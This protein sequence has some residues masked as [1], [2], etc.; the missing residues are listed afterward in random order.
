[1]EASVIGKVLRGKQ[2]A[3]L[4]RYLYGP[5]K[6]NEHVN[7]HLVAGFEH[8]ASLEPPVRPDGRR[9]FRRLTGLLSDPV[10]AL[11][12][13]NYDKPVWHC[14]VRA[15]PED[16]V[17]SDDEWADIAHT[18]MDRTG[19]SPYGDDDGVRWV[20]VRHAADHIHIVATLARQDATRPSVW[21]DFYKVRD[22]C[23]EVER[24]YGLRST[25]PGDR[26]AARRPTRAETEQTQRRGWREAPRTALRRHVIT[27]AASSG[28]EIE[29]FA[30]L[31]H[32]GVLVRK[33]MSEVTP[34]EVTGYAVALEHHTTPTGQVV[35]YG[36]GKL[37]ADLTLPKLRRRWIRPDRAAGEYQG[38]GQPRTLGSSANYRAVLRVAA[39]KAA[40][41]ASNDWEFFA[42]L[43]AAGVL[44]RPRLS[45]H[46]PGQVTGYALGIPDNLDRDG[47]QIWYG[48]AKLAADL[49]LPQLRQR[50]NNH[51]PDA[52]PGVPEPTGEE[53]TAIWDHAATTAST[54][55]DHIRAC[56]SGRTDV[57][58]D[59][60][61]ATSD[62]L[63][64]AAEALGNPRLQRVADGFDRAARRPYGRIPPA[65][66]T[67]RRLRG[68]VRLMALAGN[69]DYRTRLS[70]RLIT[71][72][73]ALADVVADLR[74][75]Q[76]RAAQAAA[77]RSAAEQ[78]VAVVPGPRSTTTLPSARRPTR[79]G[80][81]D[82]ARGDFPAAPR[83]AAPTTR[84][85]APT[86][87]DP[88]PGRGDE[89]RMPRA[90]RR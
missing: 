32:A 65:S 30:A 90:P 79:G 45:E 27:A 70:L 43:E 59:A 55:A 81:P 36:G 37:A 24:R 62:A 77:A 46:T 57:A 87:R 89:R 8:P 67:G 39:R 78:L 23:R 17:L 5:G 80:A 47:R 54:A 68:A 41:G 2:V 69:L 33:R 44:A 51:T 42:R 25:A 53:R 40:A 63:H 73:A 71:N 10:A 74:H 9:D 31:D 18:I 13:K 14:A 3:R 83:P 1:L 4:I 6:A 56:A 38:P 21:N 58:D 48:A 84:P 76:Q 28:S 88:R 20:A 16:R 12:A 22:A 52:D 15:A 60:A 50:W 34:G 49:S 66:V 7:P 19:I 29:F 85:P 72:L 26:T 86:G 11:G 64:V 82:L 75:V 61:W 35:W